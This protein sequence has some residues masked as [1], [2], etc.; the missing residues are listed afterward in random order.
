MI[1]SLKGVGGLL[2]FFFRKE[3]ETQCIYANNE[4]ES[5]IG[6]A[7]APCE[8]PVSISSFTDTRIRDKAQMLMRGHLRRARPGPIR[9]PGRKNTAIAAHPINSAT[10]SQ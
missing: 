6:V 5:A 1:L 7:S 10:L 9:Q 3:G 8:C 4:K 2:F